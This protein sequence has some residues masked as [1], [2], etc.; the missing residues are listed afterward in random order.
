MMV[1]LS[2]LTMTILI[3]FLI[4]RCSSACALVC[5]LMA[6]KADI[7]SELSVTNRAS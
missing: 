1:H 4:M 3:F 5:S 2:E 7:C 6:D